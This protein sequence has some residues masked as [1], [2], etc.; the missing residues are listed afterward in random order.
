MHQ[1]IVLIPL[2]KPTLDGFEQYSVDHSLNALRNRE[3][4]F[5]CP[6]GLDISYYIERYPNYHCRSY[7]PHY[8]ESII[9]YNHLLLS[10]FFYS[11]YLDYEF[12]LILQTDAIVLHDKLAMWCTQPFD[13]IGAPW[14]NGLELFVNLGTFQGENGRRVRATVG[15]GGLSLRRNKKCIAILKEFPEATDYF[16]R[17]GSSEDLFFSF[18]GP[19]STD[20]VLPNEITASRFSLE[21]KPSF[22][23]AINGEHLP[24]GG[25]AWWKY[26]MD[27][28]R[29]VLPLSS[30]LD[31]L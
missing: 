7:A 9:G 19:L 3:V 14:P 29:K 11:D 27:F 17:S 18:M 5:I 8:F 6:E 31:V 24:M 21:L 13:Y 15:N 30:L 2:Y 10:E 16:L 1:A 25:H 28:W 20:F 22:Y 23:Y 12:M 4:F 26:D